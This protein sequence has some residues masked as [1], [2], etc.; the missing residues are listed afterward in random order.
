MLLKR[1][2]P[3]GNVPVAVWSSS[4]WGRRPLLL[5][6]SNVSTVN[7]VL[8]TWTQ[9]Y[10]QN[11]RSLI[12]SDVGLWPLS[13]S[14]SQTNVLYCQRFSLSQLTGQSVTSLSCS[15][16]GNDSYSLQLATS[17]VSIQLS[18]SVTRKSVL[19]SLLGGPSNSSSTFSPKLSAPKR[20]RT[21][22]C[23]CCTA[24]NFEHVYDRYTTCV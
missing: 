24:A 17:N 1:G 4:F 15:Q 22:Y 5:R 13:L 3:T 18:S 21:H 23:G 9:P 11:S 20:N 2:Q 12:W 19:E 10:T 6:G 14:Q 7:S 16:L 8:Y